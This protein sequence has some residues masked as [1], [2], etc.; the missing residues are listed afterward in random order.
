VGAHG[1]L[2][3]RWEPASTRYSSCPHQHFAVLVH[4]KALGFD[5]LG[6]QILKDVIIQLK[7]SF[8]GAVGHAAASLKHDNGLI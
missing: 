1:L 6:R 4:G 7:L 8:E 2:G 5:D 3:R